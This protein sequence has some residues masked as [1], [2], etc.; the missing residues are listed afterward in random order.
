MFR[1]SWRQSQPHWDFPNPPPVKGL[2]RVNT[3]EMIENRLDDEI[4]ETGYQQRDPEKGYAQ[5]NDELKLMRQSPG[6]SLAEVIRQSIRKSSLMSLEDS[7][8]SSASING[9]TSS[10]ASVSGVSDGRKSRFQIEQRNNSAIGHYHSA[11]EMKLVT[12]V[13][14]ITSGQRQTSL[15]R[16]SQVPGLTTALGLSSNVRKSEPNNNGRDYGICLMKEMETPGIRLRSSINPYEKF[17]K[18]KSPMISDD[19]LLV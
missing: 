14:S 7:T 15:H 18:T 17:E 1:K 9:I 3:A 12:P 5:K 10:M 19:S 11:I 2:R 13:G 6:S 8:S 16:L 4:H